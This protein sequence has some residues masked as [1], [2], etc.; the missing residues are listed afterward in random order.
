[1]KYGD[2]MKSQL[3]GQVEGFDQRIKSSGSSV[4]VERFL[5][6][7]SEEGTIGSYRGVNGNPGPRSCP[8]EP[9]THGGRP[10]G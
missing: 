7:T 2:G 1:M 6:Q 3:T 10:K 4:T 9:D 5:A 8:K